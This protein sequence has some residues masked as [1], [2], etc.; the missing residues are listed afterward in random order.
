V[1]P[2]AARETGGR[3]GEVG[4]RSSEWVKIS[5]SL[6]FFVLLT[7]AIS[8][9]SLPQP[10]GLIQGDRGVTMTGVSQKG[11]HCQFDQSIPT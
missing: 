3:G 8:A 6:F 10:W 1:P 4:D 5:A 9:N 2:H 11:D 7:S